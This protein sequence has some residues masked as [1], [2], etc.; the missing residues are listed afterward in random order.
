VMRT[1]LMLPQFNSWDIWTVVVDK[2]LKSSSLSTQSGATVSTGVADVV[3]ESQ[4]F[5]SSCSIGSSR[6]A[7]NS[8]RQKYN[9][10][11]LSL[12]FTYK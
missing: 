6:K 2:W 12:G 9:D 7:S 5:T 11:Y 10:S 3:R 8:K 4:P 1:W